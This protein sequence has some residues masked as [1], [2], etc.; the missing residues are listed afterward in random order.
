MK[1]GFIQHKSMYKFYIVYDPE[2]L[3]WDLIQQYKFVIKGNCKEYI[4]STLFR[5]INVVALAVFLIFF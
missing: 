3:R 4:S 2:Y 5:I 1:S